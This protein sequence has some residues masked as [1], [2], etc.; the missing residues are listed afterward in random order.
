M[1][2]KSITKALLYREHGEP[3][4]VLS[5]EDF[6]LPALGE[7]DVEVHL[8]AAAIHPSDFGMIGGSYGRLRKLPAVAGREA[9]GRVVTLGVGVPRKLENRLV[10][11]PDSEGVWQEKFH[12]PATSLRLVPEDVDPYQAALAAVNP[13]TAYRLLRDFVSLEEGDWIIQNAG[14]SAVGVAVIQLAKEMGLRTASFVRTVEWIEPLQK[15]GADLV[16]PD[17][18][19]SSQVVRETIPEGKRKLGL[20]SVGGNSVLNVLQSLDPGGVVVTFGAM[21]FTKIRFPTRQLIFDDITFKGFWMDRWNRTHSEDERNQLLQEIDKRIAKNV[22]HTP[23]AKI[24]SLQEFEKA[25]DF[26]RKPHFGK[27]LFVPK[28]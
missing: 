3:E 6:S 7:D 17:E 26:H 9:V 19:E 18:R 5:Y 8:V 27:I 16:L 4:K 11:I 25:M 22:I 10:R 28:P 20:N 2:T 23:V 1:S 12:L 13:V 21:D 15:L 14:N 24:F